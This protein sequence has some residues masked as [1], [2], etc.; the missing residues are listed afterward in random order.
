MA[1]QWS[2]VDLAPGVIRVERSFDPQSRL[3]VTPKSR[4]GVRTVPFPGVLREYMLAHRLRSGRAHGLVVGRSATC[5]FSYTGVLWRAKRAWRDA[6]LDG[7][8]LHECRH[9]YTSFMIVAGVNAKALGTYMGHSSV[10]ITLD[11]YGT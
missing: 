10:T 3:F 7:I 8:G 1:L 11:R 2:D 5:P 9:T 4:A 6:G